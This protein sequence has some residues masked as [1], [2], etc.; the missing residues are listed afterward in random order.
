[1]NTTDILREHKLCNQHPSTPT[2]NYDKAFNATWH[3]IVLQSVSDEHI[4]HLCQCEPLEEHA[5]TVRCH[6]LDKQLSL[7]SQQ[8][9]TAACLTTQLSQNI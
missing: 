7:H 1:V 8:Q 4:E 9:S 2:I 3:K 5:D 6:H